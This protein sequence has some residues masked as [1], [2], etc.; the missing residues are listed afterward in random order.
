MSRD[1]L[2]KI[3]ADTAENGFPK[4]K[5]NYD[6]KTICPREALRRE[7]ERLKELLADLE[8]KHAKLSADYDEAQAEIERLRSIEKAG[9]CE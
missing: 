5:R 9:D 4:D 7:I 6:S 8:N 1:L 2:A 3:G